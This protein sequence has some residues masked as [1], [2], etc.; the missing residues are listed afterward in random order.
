MKIERVRRVASE[1]SVD[2]TLIDQIFVLNK[3]LLN[4]AHSIGKSSENDNETFLYF[5]MNLLNF[6]GREN[7]RRK[8]VPYLD[9]SG[10]VTKGYVR[11]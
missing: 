7:G 10:T 6:L 8:T 2:S 5:Y 4:V 1:H 3:G 9:Y 11:I